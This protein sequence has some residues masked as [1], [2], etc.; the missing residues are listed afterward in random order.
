MRVQDFEFFAP[1]NLKE[2]IELLVKN[3]GEIKILAGGQSLI[4]LLKT[5]IISM[6]MLVSLDKVVGLNYVK[7]VDGAM[8]IGAMTKVSQLEDSAIIKNK[9]P[10]LHD[11][12]LQI[13]DPLIRNSGTIGG[14]IAHADPGNDLPAVMLSLDATFKVIGPDGEREI[15]AG[16]FFVDTYTTSLE[17]NEILTEVSIPTKRSL[18][19]YV[20]FKKRAGDF[21]IAAVAVSIE[22]ASQGMVNSIGIGLTSVGPAPI[23]V[24]EAEEYAKGKSLN[25][26]TMAKIADMAADAA[27]PSSD[28]YGTAQFKREIVRLIVPEAIEKAL[29]R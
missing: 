8:K 21:S 11:A 19:S 1:D 6:P 5:R 17:T 28:F 27:E 24:K 13:A 3:E 18:G 29:K 4:P 12:V 23:S 10:T 26:E 16:D 22:L 25:R 15:K 9:L 7:E 14:N 20:K 2:V